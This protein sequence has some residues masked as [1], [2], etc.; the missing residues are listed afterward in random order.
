MT[1]RDIKI[2]LEII[3]NKY[4]L[5]LPLDTSVNYEFEKKS[6]HKNV[7]FSHGV[8]LVHEFFN[9]ERKINNNLISRSVQFLGKNSNINKLC[10]KIADRGTLI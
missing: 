1:I 5:G 6:K 7:I 8:D 3:V 10:T 2:L 4:S 9:L